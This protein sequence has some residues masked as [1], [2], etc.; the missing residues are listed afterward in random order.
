MAFLTI[1]SL[2]IHDHVMSFHL[3]VS[4]LTS[5]SSVLYKSFTSLVKFIPKYFIPF[6]VIF[7]KFFFFFCCGSFLV[8]I[9]FVTTLLLFYVWFFG[10]ET[11]GI[12]VHRH[13]Q[14]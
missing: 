3:F 2:P 1:L 5:F 10:R 9:E 6:N 14:K 7:V 4:S 13:S 8:S 12:L 11:L